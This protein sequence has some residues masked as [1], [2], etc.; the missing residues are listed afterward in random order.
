M[1][2]VIKHSIALLLAVIMMVSISPLK[3]Y[4]DDTK[5]SGI[6][7][8]DVYI[9]IDNSWSM[10]KEDD[11]VT[12]GGSDPNR[13]AIQCAEAFYQESPAN[14]SAIG[15]ITFSGKVDSVED[16]VE[17]TGQNQK[18]SWDSVYTQ[19]GTGTNI[20]AAL[21]TAG[22]KLISDGTHPNKAI[23]LI[24]DGAANV[25]KD[26]EP[27]KYN[28]KPIPVYCLYVNDGKNSD[29]QAA[30]DYLGDIA[31]RSGTGNIYEIDSSTDINGVMQDVADTLY[32]RS[33]EDKT[34]GKTP[35]KDNGDGTWTGTQ[36]VPIEADIYE[37]NCTI[38]H[39]SAATFDLTIEDPNGNILYENKKPGGPY[40]TAIDNDALTS[41]KFLWPVQGDYKFIM[42]SDTEQTVKWRTIQIVATLNLSLD[43]DNVKAGEG[44][45]AAYSIKSNT[46]A[47]IVQA[48]IRIHD[49]SG[50]V[51]DDSTD[52][53][54]KITANPDGSFTIDTTDLA[55]DTYDVVAIADMDDGKQYASIKVPF[56]VAGKKGGFPL[57]L[58]IGIAAVLLAVIAFIVF[59]VVSG[60][61]NKLGYVRPA[62]GS[63]TISVR[64]NGKLI[65]AIPLQLPGSIPDGK[66]KNLGNLVV[67]ELQRRHG[68]WDI[69]PQ[70]LGDFDISC[71]GTR[72]G[73]PATQNL[74][75]TD[76]NRVLVTQ[77][78]HGRMSSFAAGDRVDVQLK[79]TPLGTGR[80]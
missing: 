60:G 68:A 62:A 73:N 32:N 23:V 49:Q 64:D 10:A 43:K 13:L 55:E 45:N 65:S 27:V 36:V 29:E 69:I 47:K 1:K 46:S 14:N 58:I 4:A 50:K 2:K 17:N 56:T 66:P 63:L 20:S 37:F 8:T 79:W 11:G 19:D 80:R 74:E 21:D 77:I 7:P 71:V 52:G 16:L 22:Q 67:N 40:V 70:E 9:V 61:K 28:G 51:V 59:K 78:G 57:P 38:E 39:K 33:A 35:L 12:P 34:Q 44:V 30:R 48:S 25:G 3:P 42:T 5:D 54:T 41:V 6:L 76:R 72:D 15:V 24:T 53:G 75:I 26:Y 31:N 18:A